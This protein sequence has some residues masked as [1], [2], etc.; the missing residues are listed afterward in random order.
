MFLKANRYLSPIILSISHIRPFINLIYLISRVWDFLHII[1]HHVYKLL[2]LQRF[3]KS[4][5]FIS[6]QIQ[7]L[8]SFWI[9][10]KLSIWH[11]FKI[12]LNI[13]IILYIFQ[14]QTTFYS[15]AINIPPELLVSISNLA[16]FF[17]LVYLYGISLF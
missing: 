3:W 2:F 12:I 8:Q 7:I 16:Q 6:W 9:R 14:S 11:K 15:L 1:P 10:V 17:T 5:H 4:I 13:N